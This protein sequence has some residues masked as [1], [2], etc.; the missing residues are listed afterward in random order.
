MN[1]NFTPRNYSYFIEWFHSFSCSLI[2]G[3]LFFV[4]IIICY[5][6]VNINFFLTNIEYQWGEFLCGVIPILILCI[7]IIP[8]LGLLYYYGLISIYSDIS[9]KI[10][11]HQWY[12]S[13]EYCDFVNISFD[14]YIKRTDILDLGDFRLLEVDNRCV[15]P[16]NLR[17]RFC[18][19]SL[20][21][22]HSWT[23]FN[24]FIKIDAMRGIIR[25]F[26][27]RFPMVGIFYGQCSEICGANHRFMPIVLEV[28]LFNIYKNWCLIF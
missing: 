7:Q 12:W 8:S 9:L 13:Y 25:V 2:F 6:R 4:F 21:V 3:V 27:F 14:S 24:F 17:V 16:V 18:V 11:G 1:I 28:T 5:L 20:D 23:I 19:T 15:L 10:I 26:N 22:I